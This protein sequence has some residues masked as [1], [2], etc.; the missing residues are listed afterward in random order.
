M[1]VSL[2]ENAGFNLDSIEGE[3]L[4]H[5]AQTLKTGAADRVKLGNHGV[6]G[7]TTGW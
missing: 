7:N 1:R 3:K 4:P 2:K 6:F 5:F